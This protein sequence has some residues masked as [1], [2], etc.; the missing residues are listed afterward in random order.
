M[1]L[2]PASRG[3]TVR[4]RVHSPLASHVING[5][6]ARIRNLYDAKTSFS[7]SDHCCFNLVFQVFTRYSSISGLAFQVLFYPPLCHFLKYTEQM[8]VINSDFSV[9]DYL[10]LP[11]VNINAYFSLKEKL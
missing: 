8:Y 9:T 10:H 7:V 3:F 4:A 1:A 5:Q 2:S 11:K 6:L